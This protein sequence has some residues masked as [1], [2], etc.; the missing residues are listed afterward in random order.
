MNEGNQDVLHT[1]AYAISVATAVVS[2][3]ASL[4]LNY[5]AGMYATMRASNSVDDIFLDF[6]P[7]YNVTIIFVYGFLIFCTFVAILMWFDL[8]KVPFVLKTIALFVL[9]R[10][11]FVTL[12]HLA[13][14]APGIDFQNLNFVLRKLMFSGDLF[15]SA[16]TGLPFLLA[17][18]Y[19]EKKNLRYF[20]I[21][22]SIIFAATVLLGHLHYSI[23]VF[24]AYFI[25]YGVFRL[26][27][28]FFKRDYKLFAGL[29]D[30]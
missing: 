9:I 16:H 19:W 2:V 15:F 11:I 21:T 6:F 7:T 3:L 18:L 24:A 4:V 14:S 28:I 22:A 1:K 20:F 17:L 12:T 8:L 25:T 23:D 13:P 30:G 29:I 5:F 10:S 26:A 27:Q